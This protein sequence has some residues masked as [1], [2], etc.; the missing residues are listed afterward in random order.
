M[1]RHLAALFTCIAIQQAVL[2][3]TGSLKEEIAVQMA[4][5]SVWANAVVDVLRE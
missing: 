1:V 2:F 4:R 3:L 5:T